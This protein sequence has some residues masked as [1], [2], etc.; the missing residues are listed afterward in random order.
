[1]TIEDY[2]T[3]DAE[4]LNAQRVVAKILEPII[5][6]NTMDFSKIDLVTVAEFLLV[7]N[8]GII[9][10]YCEQRSRVA[11]EEQDVFEFNFIAHFQWYK[12]YTDNDHNIRD[13]GGVNL[14]TSA[15]LYYRELR[16]KHK[17]TQPSELK[18]NEL[19]VMDAIFRAL[20]AA[21]H[22]NAK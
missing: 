20:L 14:A 22:L 9:S 21:A 11:V 19:S 16:E 1:M 8:K 5:S 18:I 4:D 6:T 17:D 15:I 12:N 2:E 7:S 10:R 3:G 13:K